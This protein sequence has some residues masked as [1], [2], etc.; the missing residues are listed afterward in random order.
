MKLWDYLRQAEVL[1]SGGGVYGESAEVADT[2]D[3]FELSEA[4]LEVGTYAVPA[5]P[6]M[7]TMEGNVALVYQQHRQNAIEAVF[8]RIS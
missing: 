8:W 6:K 5:C 2:S 7:K 3:S 4:D 1:D